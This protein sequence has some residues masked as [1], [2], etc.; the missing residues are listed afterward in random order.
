[1][2]IALVQLCN[3]SDE[4]ANLERAR[5]HL[6]KGVEEGADLVLFPENLPAVWPDQ[7]KV[8]EAQP[9][10]GPRV[11]RICEWA[12]DACVW[13]L[14]GSVPVESGDPERIYNTS[15]LI[16]SEGRVVASYRKVH[17]FDV[18]VPG[19]QAYR[20]SAN[21]LGGDDLVV[22]DTPWGKLGMTVCYD[23]RF[24]EQYLRLR[25]AGASIITAPSAFTAPTG[26]AHWEV[27]VRARALDSQCFVLAPNQWGYHGG[28]RASYGHSMAV[29]PWG[30]VLTC[31]E[32]G[33]G[34]A[35]A[36]LDLD[37]VDRI[38]QRI[39]LRAHRKARRWEPQ[40]G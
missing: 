39:P 7:H 11:A 22:A 35:V 25:E 10:D 20:E 24:P 40:E 23:L 29:D 15:V 8:S 37:Q 17:L 38:R 3:N 6:W 4:E 31:L 19:Q 34:I 2:K 26:R 1:M 13:I 16:S 28:R 9:L 18:E 36:E 21:V 27:L 14:A 32:D 12:S 33:E 30:Q 5:A